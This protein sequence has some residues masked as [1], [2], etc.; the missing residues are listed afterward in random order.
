VIAAA[1]PKALAA[2]LAPGMAITQARVL[3]AGLDIRPAD[4]EGDRA[5]LES[6]ALAL[7]RRWAPSVAIAGQDSLFIDLTGVAHLHGG[8]ARMAA[9]LRRMLAR[10]GFAS[11]IAVA[12]TPGGAACRG[13][14]PAAD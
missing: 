8:E 14:C 13:H 2:G 5:A 6:L 7:T 3:V 12:D 10:F 1:C 11:R 4:P 9:R